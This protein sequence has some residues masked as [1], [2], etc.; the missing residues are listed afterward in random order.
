MTE[1]DIKCLINTKTKNERGC[2]DT[3]LKNDI[4]LAS[5]LKKHGGVE[6]IPN[7]KDKG[8]RSSASGQDNQGWWG[9]S[10][11]W[12]ERTERTNWHERRNAASSSGAYRENNQNSDWKRGG[13]RW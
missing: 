1:D 13:K 12:G 5:T 8:D 6:Q 2:V 11:S 9:D 4:T 10:N 7:P 3:A